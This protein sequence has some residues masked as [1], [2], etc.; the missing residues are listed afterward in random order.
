MNPMLNSI[1]R[2]VI[3]EI[4]FLKNNQ[5]LRHE[6]AQTDSDAYEW[7]CQFLLGGTGT[8]IYNNTDGMCQHPE[9]HPKNDDRKKCMR[10]ERYVGTTWGRPPARV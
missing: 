6:Q 10:V 4:R 2:E 3:A 9:C 7:P 1:T 8:A 5:H